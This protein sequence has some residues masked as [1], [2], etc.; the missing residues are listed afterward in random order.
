MFE[1]AHLLPGYSGGTGKIWNLNN[2]TKSHGNIILNFLFKHIIDS[3]L[4]K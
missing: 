2:L 4:E 3:F 1:V